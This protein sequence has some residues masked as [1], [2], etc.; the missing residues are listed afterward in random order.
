MS[1]PGI[2]RG[3]VWTFALTAFALLPAC[4]EEAPGPSTR[5]EIEVR[6]PKSPSFE[7]RPEA[8]KHAD[9]ALSIAGLLYNADRSAGQEVTVRG[10]VADTVPC[11]PDPAAEPPKSRKGRAAAQ[12]CHPPSHLYL[13]DDVEAQQDRLLVVGWSRGKVLGVRRGQELTFHGRFQRVSPGGT[14]IR[15]A[16]LLVVAE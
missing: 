9:G 6:L 13:A 14:F 3:A 4:E 15:Q 11:T 5:S 12:E 10:L 2:C 1:S 8:P 16:G 7:A